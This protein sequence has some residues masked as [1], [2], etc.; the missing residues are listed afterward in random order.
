MP[1]G[2][3][4]A[5]RV[6]RE[7]GWPQ[8]IKRTVPAPPK[9][10]VHVARGETLAPRRRV[11]PS[12]DFVAKCACA[13]CNNGW[14][15]NLEG[16][17]KPILLPLIRGETRVLDG[18]EQVTLTRWALKTAMVL[19]FSHPKGLAIPPTDRQKL[20]EG[21]LPEHAQVWVALYN[22]TNNTLYYHDQ[23]RVPTP[24]KSGALLAYAVT[25]AV[26]CVL[27]H[28]WVPATA[29]RRVEN[30]GALSV[31]LHQIHPDR[32]SVTVGPDGLDDEGVAWVVASQRNPIP[33]D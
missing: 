18:S 14:M 28:I 20:R 7:H 31:M 19:E 29:D 13:D 22:G 16:E 24:D 26:G 12:F 23:H 4:D 3:C 5:Q 27:F 1:C 21:T 25:F 30:I 9:R 33:A 32:S 8:W 15:A 6:T 10:V 2:F 17:G 11:G